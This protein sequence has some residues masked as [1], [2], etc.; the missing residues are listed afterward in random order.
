MLGGLEGW[1]EGTKRQLLAFYEGLL[2]DSLERTRQPPTQ[3]TLID[4]I[5]IRVDGPMDMDDGPKLP[6]PSKERTSHILL[7]VPPLLNAALASPSPPISSSMTKYRLERLVASL[8]QLKPD[9]P[10]DLLDIIAYGS[11]AA[12]SSAY[13][14]LETTYP[15]CLDP[16]TI[17]RRPQGVVNVESPPKSEPLVTLPLPTILNP[18]PRVED[19]IA[20]IESSLRDHDPSIQEAGLLLLSRQCPP[21]PF[22]SHYALERVARAVI[23]WILDESTL[24]KITQR[25]AASTTASLAQSNRDFPSRDHEKD[26]SDYIAQRASLLATI[27]VPYLSSIHQ[28]DAGAY[29]DIIFSQTASISVVRDDVPGSVRPKGLESLQATVSSTMDLQGAFVD[30]LRPQDPMD[31]LADTLLRNLVRL[32]QSEVTFSVFHD[33]FIRWL[34]EVCLNWPSLRR[35]DGVVSKLTTSFSSIIDVDSL[36]SYCPSVNSLAYSNLLICRDTRVGRLSYPS[37]TTDHRS[38]L[39]KSSSVLPTTALKACAALSDGPVSLLS[40]G[41][42]IESEFP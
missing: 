12:R 3:S 25:S 22:V 38:N 4:G 16:N 28:L 36:L 17:T 42:P 14:L 8:V 21:T 9:L 6:T 23:S 26:G 2:V 27:A 5:T 10:F 34:D 29:A 15:T 30:I 7:L 41:E 1:G 24:F 40:Q 18:S 13:S 33:L 31:S 32:C 19:L 35:P 39:G 11:S 20:A 37:R